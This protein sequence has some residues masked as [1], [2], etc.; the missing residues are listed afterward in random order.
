[1][2]GHPNAAAA[3]APGPAG[4][5]APGRQAAAP[6]QVNVVLVPDMVQLDMTGP[7]E[8]LARVPGW[9]VSLVAATM[10]PV[11]TDRGLRI[12][13]DVTREGAAPADLLVV[14]GGA[15]V[16]VAMLDPAWL[17]FVRRQANSA[18]HVFGICTGSLLLGA[19]GLLRGRRAG[20]HWQARDLL[21][22]FGATPSDDRLT[23]D[24]KFYT[25]GGVTSGIDLALRVVADLEG[26]TVARKIQLAIEYDPQPPFAGGTPATSPPA[27]VQAVLADSRRRRAEREGRV[28]EAAERLG[29][30]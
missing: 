18:A 8:V 3:S 19:A 7:F 20:G 15:G 30:T 12:V 6:R 23:V 25:S 14:P 29:R 4:E 9:S 22:R 16:D 28:A 10:E 11:R 27:I 26:E 24:G 5:G 1:M 2:S 13:P 17:A 21:A